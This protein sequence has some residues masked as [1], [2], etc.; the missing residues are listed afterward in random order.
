MTEQTFDPDVVIVSRQLGPPPVVLYERVSTGERWTV[1]G[2]CNQCGL[3]VVGTGTPE[4]YA[5]DGPVGT[6]LA[7]RD[8]RY[9]DR[10][11]EPLAP[12]FIE[13]MQQVAA[14]TPTATVSGCS[15][16]IQVIE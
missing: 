13:D 3:C 11:D 10:M 15:L 4:F 9:P 7:V 1:T 6:P 12:G 2:V 8:L 16:T 5:W 14:E